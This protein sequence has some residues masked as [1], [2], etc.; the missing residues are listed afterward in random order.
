M[1]KLGALKHSIAAAAFAALMCWALGAQAAYVSYNS[2]AEFSTTENPTG[3]WSYGSWSGSHP[4]TTLPVAEDESWRGVPAGLIEWYNGNHATPD[5]GV[6]Y[7]SLDTTYS[8]FGLSWPAHSVTLDS[9]GGS[10]PGGWPCIRFTAPA[11]GVYDISAVTASL[12]GNTLGLYI[13]SSVFS[14]GYEYG[15]TGPSYSHTNLTLTAGQSLCFV[16]NVG[17]IM[18]IDVTVTGNTTEASRWLGT[19]TAGHNWTDSDN[20]SLGVP[21]NV[22]DAAALLDLSGGG[23]STITV[24]APVTLGLWT[25]NST[26]SSYSIE[27]S[28]AVTLQNTGTS[29][30]VISVKG[31]HVISV[32]LVNNGPLTIGFDGPTDSLTLNGAF[33]EGA[34]PGSITVGGGGTLELA[35]FPTPGSAQEFNLGG[36]AL[37]YTGDPVTVT[38]PVSCNNDCTFTVANSLTFEDNFS[39]LSVAFTKNGPGALNF[40]RTLAGN[41]L[42]RGNLLATEGTV[43]FDGVEGSTYSFWTWQCGA[44]SGTSAIMTTSGNCQI[45]LAS[46]ASFGDGGSASLTMD[47]ASQLSTP[48][49]RFGIEGGSVLVTMEGTSS[50]Q[51]AKLSVGKDAWFGVTTS[52]SSPSY[53]TVNLNGYAELHT[54]TAIGNN[55]HLG[56]GSGSTVAFTLSGHS[57]FSYEGV[58]TWANDG[59]VDIADSG[60]TADV[61]LNGSATV[62]VPNGCVLVGGNALNQAADVMTG[63]KGTVTLNGTSTFTAGRVVMVGDSLAEGVLTLNGGAFTAPAL[64]CGESTVGAT[65]NFN[66]GTLKAAEASNLGYYDHQQT[67]TATG[68]GDFIQGAGFAVNVME[69][70][71]AIDTSGLA[72]TVTSVLHHAGENEIDG[73]LTKLGEGSLKLTNQ[74]SY[75][76]PT[77]IQQGLLEI[78]YAAD[79][80]NLPGGITGN[81]DLTVDAGVSLTTPSITVGTLTIG[82]TRASAAP[83]PEPGTCVLLAL[84]GLSLLW[85]ARRR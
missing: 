64:V 12:T 21:R 2:T 25:I 17:G 56:W 71:A 4:Y 7:N 82:G 5:P 20:W 62:S 31:N 85:A 79:A 15:G 57:L 10:E 48:Y 44:Q 59:L 76:G 55:T 39:S 52:S 61:V 47:G 32:P 30:A 53:A 41:T 33:S 29:S 74:L 43:A 1:K 69:H 60:A 6:L 68:S 46:W 83:V 81:G 67:Y 16:T 24:D 35:Y 40:N 84:A 42:F 78:A 70:G 37:N 23:S 50:D 11:N 80:V 27:G 49:A 34:T 36:G 18:Q 14:G 73:G 3:V 75:T 63:T 26:S 28:N 72:V 54:A 77:D 45:S 9:Y 51:F 38:R 22:G 8:G 66:G 58:N 65:I 13:G 19:S